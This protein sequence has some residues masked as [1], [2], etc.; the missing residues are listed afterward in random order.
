[1]KPVVS[2]LHLVRRNRRGIADHEPALA[3]IVGFQRGYFR[4]TLRVIIDEVVHIGALVR[5]DTPDSFAYRT[6]EGGVSF[7]ID[8]V[9]RN[10]GAVEQ[11]RADD[12][13]ALLLGER[14][15]RLGQR[16]GVDLARI[17]ASSR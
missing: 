1:M 5:H 2:T 12:A 10:L 16:G 4:I 15:V 8:P 9:G 7:G 6:V 17:I 13:A 3:Q 14:D 11:R